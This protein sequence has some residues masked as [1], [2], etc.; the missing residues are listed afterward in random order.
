MH[1]LG[2]LKIIKANLEH[3]KIIWE[4]RND[5]ITRKMSNSNSLISFNNHDKWFRKAILD[6]DNIIYIGLY[7][8]IPFGMTR[9]DKLLDRKDIYIISINISPTK[10]NLGLG[11]FLL[12]NSIQKIFKE[13]ESC[14]K[15]IADIKVKNVVSCKLFESCGF[16]LSEINDQKKIYAFY[17]IIN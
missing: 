6:I 1:L 7:Q 4:W 3:S 15:V 9:F 2:K 8:N 16:N 5:S 17:R 11:K 10:R 14:K 13:D 12:K